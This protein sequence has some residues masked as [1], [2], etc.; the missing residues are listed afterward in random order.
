MSLKVVSQAIMQSLQK[1]KSAL[2]PFVLSASSFHSFFF[3]FA[4]ALA[5]LICCSFTGGTT[6]TRAIWTPSKTSRRCTLRAKSKTLGCAFSFL[7]H[8]PNLTVACHSVLTLL[9]VC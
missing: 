1:L 9:I 8:T 5:A 3:V 6:T 2:P 4:S 7:H